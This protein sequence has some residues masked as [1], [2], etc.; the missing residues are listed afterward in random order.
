LSTVGDSLSVPGD[1]LGD[2]LAEG[3]DV[4]ADV[5]G[6]GFGDGEVGDG[7]TAAGEVCATGAAGVLGGAVIVMVT[8]G[9]ALR[10]RCRW[11]LSK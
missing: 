5:V 8:V 3:V 6:G 4:G 2:G 7:V 9:L 11:W 1:G 10:W